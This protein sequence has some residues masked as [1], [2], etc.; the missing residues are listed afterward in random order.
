MW[1][2]RQRAG[3][4]FH[5]EISLCIFT[6]CK[7][8]VTSQSD[9]ITHYF[10]KKSVYGVVGSAENVFGGDQGTLYTIDPYLEFC[11]QLLGPIELNT[12]CPVLYSCYSLFPLFVVLASAIRRKETKQSLLGKTYAHSVLLLIIQQFRLS[13]G[14]CDTISI[15]WHLVWYLICTN[16]LICWSEINKLFIT[17]GIHY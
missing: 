6:V 3:A 13:S 17:S 5:Q 4:S 1:L 12:S 10:Q 2:C 16:S 15:Y 14:I 11:I 7:R 8:S 9:N